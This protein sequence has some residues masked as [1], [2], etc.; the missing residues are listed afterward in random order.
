MKKDT[1]KHPQPKPSR[2]VLKKETLRKLRPEDL[3][4]AGGGSALGIPISILT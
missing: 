4:A 3:E 2:L 1:E